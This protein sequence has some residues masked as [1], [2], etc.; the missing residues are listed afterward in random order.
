MA[1]TDIAK[2]EMPDAGAIEAV[3]VGGDL[4]KLSAP[5]RV[6]YY[7]SVCKS[8]GLNPLTRPFDYINLNGK[9]T[10]YARKDATDQLR[11]LHRISIDKPSIDIQDEWIVV[12]V[13]ARDADGRTDADVGVVSRKDMRGDFGNSLMKAVTKAKRR[14]TLSICGLGMFDETE[15]ETADA[16]PVAVDVRTGEIVPGQPDASNGGNGQ[17]LQPPKRKSA[18]QQTDAPP[19]VTVSCVDPG[20]HNGR[21]I[22]RIT[23]SDGRKGATDDKDIAGAAQNALDSGIAVDVAMEPGQKPGTFRVVEIAPVVEG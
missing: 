23:L 13:S 6:S 7:H 20:K 22:W 17:T 16:R 21:D 14:V 2:R 3:V 12:S 8:L 19:V 5:Q 1:T 15:L 10:L 11:Q 4:A 18:Q 9:L